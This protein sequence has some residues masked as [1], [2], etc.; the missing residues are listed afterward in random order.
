MKGFLLTN[1]IGGYFLSGIKS[2]YSGLFLRDSENMFKVIDEIKIIGNNVKP[3]LFMPHGYNSL[4]YELGKLRT[5]ELLLDCRGSYDISEW[6]R[7]YEIFEEQGKIIVKGIKK[8]GDVEL[9]LYLVI[10]KQNVVFSKTEK[11]V[12]KKYI[13]DKK[14]KSHPYEWHVFSALKLKSRRIVF[15]VGK[16]KDE[17]IKEN[18]FV[19]S[20]LV[21]LKKKQELYY[22]KL[23]SGIKLKNKKIETAYKHAVSSLDN[24]SCNIHGVEGIYAG[25]PWFFQFWSRDELISLS[26]LVNKRKAKKILISYLDCIVRD[27]RLLNFRFPGSDKTNAD[28]IGWLFKRLEGVN[29]N[30][31]E[32]AVVVKKLKFSI[33]NI[34]G[35]L[36]KDGLI[37]SRELETWMDTNWMDDTREG[38]RIEIQAMFLFMLKLAYKLT[39]DKKYK[40]E[41]EQMRLLVRDK[42]WD[43]KILAD[44]L[45][46][47][48]VRPNLFI[49]AYFYP[50]LLTKEEWSLCFQYA[51][52]RLWLDWGGLA[53]ISK[54]HHLFCKLYS[55]ELPRSYHRGDS[56]FWLND[57]AALVMLR[58]DPNRFKKYI[59]KIVNAS[60]KDIFEGI[61][62]S[63]SELSSAKELR[64]EGCLCQAWSNA[65]FI[66][67]VDSL[68]L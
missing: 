50:E 53:T 19:C 57:L 10:D 34:K 33:D 49:A 46:D 45:N 31:K 38:F 40:K 18:N 68:A 9:V 55:G 65:M 36:M 59:D 20:N 12:K 15:S 43:G 3:V 4:V 11:W 23:F 24:L 56:W 51:L 63:H 54:N 26:G 32:T 39:K 30:K 48:T 27:G 61:F 47:F 58:N 16:D 41:E 6:G 13:F 44:G 62:G 52:S 29:L 17:V 60:V 25:L 64:H 67:L 22:K 35:H 2:R 21:K 14:R 8:E 7:F 28:G 37:H 66:E 42:F 5:I 1:K